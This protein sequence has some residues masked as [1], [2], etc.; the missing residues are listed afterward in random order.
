MRPLFIDCAYERFGDELDNPSTIDREGNTLG[1]VFSITEFDY[2]PCCDDCFEEIDCSIIWP[3]YCKECGQGCDSGYEFCSQA[4][5]I[6][7]Q[8]W[9]AYMYG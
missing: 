2:Q 1:A 6:D 9:L 7:Y 5:M 3:N 4:C 8:T